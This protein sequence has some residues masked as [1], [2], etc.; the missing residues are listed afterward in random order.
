[1]KILDKAFLGADI[2]GSVGE[3]KK[4]FNSGNQYDNIMGNNTFK[5]KNIS[6]SLNAS[7]NNK[8]ANSMSIVNEFYMDKIASSSVSFDFTKNKAEQQKQYADALRKYKVSIKGDPDFVSKMN[9]F[10]DSL[11]NDYN[12]QRNIHD[13]AKNIDN[14]DPYKTDKVNE[15][16]SGLDRAEA[17]QNSRNA[18]KQAK[19]EKARASASKFENSKFGKA[20]KN[21]FGYMDDVRYN[22]NKKVKLKSA[23]KAMK[24]GVPAMAAIGAGSY[25]ITKGLQKLEDSSNDKQYKGNEIMNPGRSI[26]PAVAGGVAGS[27]YLAKSLKDKNFV[28]PMKIFK[29]V[30][31]KEAS[32]IP[33]K[34]LQRSGKA[35]RFMGNVQSGVKNS[36]RKESS[37]SFLE[38]GILKQASAKDTAKKLIVDD[39]LK[40]G[41]KA[42]PY[43]AAPAA[44]SAIV[45]KDIRRGGADI[46]HDYNQVTTVDVPLNRKTER[47]IKKLTKTAGLNI[48]KA[49]MKEFWVDEM[50]S[51]SA[52]GLGR[53]VIP[54]AIVSAT[55]YNIMNAMENVK[56]N[57]NNKP[58]QQGQARITIETPVEKAK[59][60]SDIIDCLY[61]LAYSD[62]DENENEDDDQD[63]SKMA[64][65]PHTGLPEKHFTARKMAVGIKKKQKTLM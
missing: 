12:K 46:R 49:K 38:E 10:K 30:A 16:K 20:Q 65:N 9:T 34:V 26:F 51:R 35:G 41:V 27:A 6:G 55:G 47:N 54:T 58:I 32:K 31:S 61:K 18:K 5:Q 22:K 15:F 45:G 42:V 57:P 13:F 63:D 3:T 40:E 24:F 60:A 33:I 50:A 36:I 21:F 17:K 52:Q 53:A 44:L 8:L 48:N 29:N 62:E 56:D 39:F 19:A 28:T 23:A 25:G 43:F 14:S 59:T 64:I 37:H 2:I 4:T 7:V 11:A 1:M